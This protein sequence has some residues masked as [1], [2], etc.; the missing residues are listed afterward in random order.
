MVDE[1]RDALEAVADGSVGIGPRGAG[2]GSLE[3]GRVGTSSLGRMGRVELS[4]G[5]LRRLGRYEVR[6]YLTYRLPK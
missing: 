6:R 3:V 5:L 1:D 2:Q 4:A